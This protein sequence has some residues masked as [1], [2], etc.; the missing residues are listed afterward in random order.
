[1]QH[2]RL[3]PVQCIEDSSSLIKHAVDFR[4]LCSAKTKTKTTTTTTKN[5]NKEQ[6]QRTTTKN[7]KSKTNQT[8]QKE[9]WILNHP[10][11][12]TQCT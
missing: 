8:N 1:M 5:N 2:S 3:K 4:V 12:K 10:T 9:G 6:Q 7:N 11:N